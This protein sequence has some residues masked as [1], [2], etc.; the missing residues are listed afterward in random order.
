MSTREP[1][2]AESP[3]FRCPV[4]GKSLPYDP[5]VPRFDAPCSGCGG[6]IWC[7]RRVAR[8][9]TLL[10]VLPDRMPEPWDVEQIAD[11]LIREDAA[12]EV[13]VVLHRLVSLESAFV[14]RLVTL[15]K[16]IR[17]SGGRLVLCGLSPVVR[18][19]FEHLRLDRAFDISDGGIEVMQSD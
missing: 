7:R 12:S 18:E 6:M 17:S 11:A 4:C 14:A 1:Q 2:A 3:S 16:R 9:K 19:V 15:N 10:E 8:G 13:V 5:P